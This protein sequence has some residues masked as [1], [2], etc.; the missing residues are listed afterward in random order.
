MRTGHRWNLYARR[1]AVPALA[2]HFAVAC[3]PVTRPAVAACLGVR[4][5]SSATSS[6]P[7]GGFCS[8]LSFNGLHHA[9][10]ITPQAL[11]GNVVLLVNTASYCGYTPQLAGLQALHKSYAARGLVVL[12]VPSNDFGAQEP[13]GEDAIEKF[14]K[15]VYGV[16]FPVTSKQCVV[17]GGAHPSFQFL[18]ATLGEAGTPSWNF[19]KWLVARN[20]D[21]VALFAPAVD[22]LDST[23]TQA[24]ETE[25]AVGD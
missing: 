6:S 3:S 25:L 2:P 19:G 20:G 22:P 24:I 8:L 10:A 4:R 9:A 13:D 7:L 14:Y 16:S 12:A 21:L 1:R 23:V 5:A 17:G 11:Q 15:S 18:A